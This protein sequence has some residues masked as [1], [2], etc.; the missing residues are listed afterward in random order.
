MLRYAVLHY[1]MHAQHGGHCGNAEIMG[2][3]H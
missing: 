1:A 2:R 3:D